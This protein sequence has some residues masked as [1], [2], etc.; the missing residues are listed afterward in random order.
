MVSDA[1][2]KDDGSAADCLRAAVRRGRYT[3]ASEEEMMTWRAQ[4]KEERLER[5][6]ARAAENEKANKEKSAFM[7]ERKRKGAHEDTLEHKKRAKEKVC[8]EA[9]IEELWG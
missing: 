9:A 3:L 5:G 6:R 4:A 1:L 7:K 2:T 8:L